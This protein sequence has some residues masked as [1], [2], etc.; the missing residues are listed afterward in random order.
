MFWWILYYVIVTSR[1]AS[2]VL[3]NIHCVNLESFRPEIEKIEP[4]LETVKMQQGY[5]TSL[6]NQI[7]F[8]QFFS[9][10]LNFK[11]FENRRFDNGWANSY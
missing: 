6:V 4:S 7:C 9:S 2:F 8:Q 10:C 5:L 1:E 3:C 11:H